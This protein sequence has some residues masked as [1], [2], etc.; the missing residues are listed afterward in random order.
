VRPQDRSDCESWI[1][2]DSFPDLAVAA[3]LMDRPLAGSVSQPAFPNPR[4]LYWHLHST[5]N[6]RST[7]MRIVVHIPARAEWRALLHE[8]PT[9][10]PSQRVPVGEVITFDWSPNTSPIELI[11]LRGGVGKIRAAA[12]T[13]YAICTWQPDLYLVLGT[14]GAVDPNVQELDLVWANQ[15]IISDFQHGLTTTGVNTLITDHQMRCPHDWSACVFPLP[16]RPGV[17]A[18]ADGDVTHHNVSWLHTTFAATI[19]DWESGAIAYVC[20]VNAIPWLILRGVSD[21][22]TTP[23]DHQYQRF[24][25]NTPIVMQR[26]W[27]LVPSVLTAAPLVL[28]QHT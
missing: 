12:S 22:P 4:M 2:P 26:L 24:Q 14:A 19:A 3:Q 17:I 16:V 27:S 8:L 15:T 9:Q 7:V 20:A 1:R 21:V 13:Q 28:K 11:V 23:P 6:E 10:A 25:H 5:S 18:T